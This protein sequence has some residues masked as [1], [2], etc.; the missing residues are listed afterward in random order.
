MQKN[1]WYWIELFVQ[2]N[3]NWNYLTEET[4][5]TLMSKQMNSNS[6]QN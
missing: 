6:F 5:A 1:G 3:N 2:D 4:S